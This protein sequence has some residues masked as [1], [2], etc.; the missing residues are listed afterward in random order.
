MVKLHQIC[1]GTVITDIGTKLL[2]S[3]KVTWVR[4]FVK[5]EKNK[6]VIFCAY[7]AEISRISQELVEMKVPHET[8][9]GGNTDKRSWIKFQEEDKIK[10][11]VCQFRSGSQSINL[12]ASNIL[13][14]YSAS[15]SY[16]DFDQSLGR[17][18]RRG[19]SKET[20]AY[21]LKTAGTIDE[22]IYKNLS[23]KGKL[24]NFVFNG[25]R[26]KRS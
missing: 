6:I 18:R 17:I 14:Y 24:L 1:G 13:I 21:F 4:E 20:H 9:F 11:M 25:L 16:I 7:N 19:Q 10:V 3:A 26:K 12:H 2:P 23:K 5:R 15:F 8:L 22:L